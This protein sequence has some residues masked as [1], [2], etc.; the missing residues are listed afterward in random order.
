[1]GNLEDTMIPT[2]TVISV[3]VGAPRTVDGFGRRVQTAIWKSPVDGPVALQGVNF[4]GDDQADR[5]VHGG[6]AM[7]VYA[8]AIEDYRWWSE[9]IGEPLAPGTFGENLTLESVDLDSLVVGDTWTIGTAR[10][11]VTQP[12]FP[13]FKLGIRMGDAGFV[14][15]FA[16][17]RRFGTYFAIEVAGAVA[18]GDR[19][20]LHSHPDDAELRIGE[21]VA[22]HEDNDAALLSRIAG[23][24]HVPD[25]WREH[26][27]KVVAR[28][29]RSDEARS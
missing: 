19:A 29:T 9:L 15:V 24:R 22:A 27:A 11:R 17:A 8:Y 13:C 2:G 10:L 26:A 4:D 1:M 16:A 12:R 23:D 3:N 6:V 25:D 18:A 14:D 7:S 5:R 21:F 28:L 20:E